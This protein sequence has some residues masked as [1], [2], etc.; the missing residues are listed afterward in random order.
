MA[1]RDL[2][3]L[4][5]QQKYLQTEQGKLARDRDAERWRQG[6]QALRQQG[7]PAAEAKKRARQAAR[8]LLPMPRER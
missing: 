8:E 3:H 7:L 6:Y 4:L 5:A 1:A 2:A